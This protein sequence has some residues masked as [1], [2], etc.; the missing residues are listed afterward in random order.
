MFSLTDWEVLV[1]DAGIFS[2]LDRESVKMV[3]LQ[4]HTENNTGCHHRV[5]TVAAAVAATDPGIGI[6]PYRDTTWLAEAFSHPTYSSRYHQV[7]VTYACIKINT[8]NNGNVDHQLLSTP[9]CA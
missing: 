4:V 3:F 2:M 1:E 7:G 5:F 9:M 6:G 8:K